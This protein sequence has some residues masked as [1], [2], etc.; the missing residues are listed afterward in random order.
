MT[1]LD[2]R[3][4]AKNGKR[5]SMTLPKLIACSVA[6]SLSISLPT[7]ADAQYE[8][9]NDP[10]RV[11]A[12]A[13]FAKVNS[14]IGINGDLLPPIPPIDVEDVLGVDDGKVVAWAGVSWHF[15]NRH[16]IELEYFFLNR[17]NT[18]SDTFAPPI[19]IGDFFIEDGQISTSYDTDIARLTYGFSAIRSDRTDLQLKTGLHLASL[20]TGVKLSGS[21][22][23]PT[24]TPSM[25]PGCPTAGV[26]VD[27]LGVSTPLPHVGV[28]YGYALS[29]TVAFSA[30]AMG[31]AVKLGSIDGSI[32]E[33]D[34]DV[35][36]QPWRNIG[37]GVGARYFRTSVDSTGS[38]LN[39]SFKLEHFGSTLYMQ[40]VF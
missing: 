33:I 18:R 20:N 35:V 13:F 39:G 34:A 19:Q 9:F 29:P 4:V 14:E 12:G 40:A 11:Y 17:S 16:S 23:D 28:S 24:T 7:S 1:G 25:P 10:W 36:W 22:C 37:F 5:G 31:F 26:G 21:V 8:K 32:I 15:A 3:P 2:Q 27:S 30:A 38:E 6:T